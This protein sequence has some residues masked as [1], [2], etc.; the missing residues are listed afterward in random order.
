M[1]FEGESYE[2]KDMRQLYIAYSL[3][4]W[5]RQHLYSGTIKDAQHIMDNNLYEQFC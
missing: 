4:W 2:R 1:E 3:K 5:E